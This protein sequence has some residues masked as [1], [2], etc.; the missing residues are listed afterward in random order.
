MVGLVLTVYVTFAVAEIRARYIRQALLRASL[1]RFEKHRRTLE[2]AHRKKDV[3]KLR[4]TFSRCIGIIDELSRYFQD[5][6]SVESTGRR[7][8]S[9]C[10][11]RSDETLLSESPALISRIA[12]LVEQLQ[13]RVVQIEWGDRNV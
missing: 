8:R 6:E 9:I 1:D 2:T 4:N 11:G 5:I 10:S 13:V 3:D 12:G 7:L